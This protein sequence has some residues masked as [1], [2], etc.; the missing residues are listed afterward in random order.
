MVKMNYDQ[1]KNYS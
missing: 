1:I